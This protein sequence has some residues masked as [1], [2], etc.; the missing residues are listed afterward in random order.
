MLSIKEILTT[1]AKAVIEKSSQL[2]G[3]VDTKVS[4]LRSEYETFYSQV[5]G[6]FQN[7]FKAFDEVERLHDITEDEIRE[8]VK[9]AME[10]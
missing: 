7:V 4:A 10:S 2:T 8:I 3:E 6:T 9:N 1:L 5:E